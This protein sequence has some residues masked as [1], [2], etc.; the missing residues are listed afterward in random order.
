MPNKTRREFLR[1]AAGV[2]LA[3]TNP[4]FLLGTAR[5]QVQAWVTSKDR[6][7]EEVKLGEW[8]AFSG[9]D[10]AGVTIDAGKRFREMLTTRCTF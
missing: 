10:A 9:E 4:R 5:P 6:R 3:A 7:L 2:T 8:H 1:L